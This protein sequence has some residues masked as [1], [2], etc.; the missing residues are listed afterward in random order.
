M[1]MRVTMTSKEVAAG[2]HI[3]LQDAFEKVFMA[4]LAPKD[5]AMFGY[6][7]SYDE[8]GFYFSPGAVLIFASVLTSYGAEECSAPPRANASLLV[9]HNDAWDF[10]I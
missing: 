9:A 8:Y 6:D 3:A 1:W 10:L 2:R 4:A 7:K 5:A